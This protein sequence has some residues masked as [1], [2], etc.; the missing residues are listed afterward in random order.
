MR[1]LHIFRIY[2]ILSTLLLLTFYPHC[3]SF[4]PCP[5]I[6]F[7]F[8][9]CHEHLNQKGKK[10]NLYTFR[11]HL[12]SGVCGFIIPHVDEKGKWQLLWNKTI[13]DQLLFQKQPIFTLMSAALIVMEMLLDYSSNL[14][15]ALSLYRTV[16]MNMLVRCIRRRITVTSG[17]LVVWSSMVLLWVSK[18]VIICQINLLCVCFP[19]SHMS[20]ISIF[21]L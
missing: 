12:A 14:L 21:S 3:I 19:E 8:H 10:K 15:F 11:F 13:F 17:L 9:E 7:Y 2:F 16:N 18:H 6:F 1:V 5:S 20:F 4:F